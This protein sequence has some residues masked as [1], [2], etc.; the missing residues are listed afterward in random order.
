[1]FFTIF[2]H[3]LNFWFRQISTYVY[4]FSFLFVSMLLMAGTAGLFDGPTAAVGTIEFVNSPSSIFLGIDF[5]NRFIL[6]LLPIIVGLSVYRDYSSRIHSIMYTF[7]FTKQDY[8]IAK[9]LSSFLVTVLI[10]SMIGV[11]LAIGATLP[12]IDEKQIGPFNLIAYLQTYF[13]FIIPNLLFFGS[14]IFSI[15]SISRNIYA[16]FITVIVL[17][18]IQQISQ[19][20]FS[21]LDDLFLSAILDPFGKVA[22]FIDTSNWTTEDK[23]VKLLPISKYLIYNRLLFLSITA[24]IVSLF[25]KNFK[26]EE[27]GKK[28]KL[29][30][31]GKSN[32]LRTKIKRNTKVILDEVKFSF[33]LLDKLK[34]MF[35]LAK[36]DYKYIL[37]SWPFIII[38]LSS[39]IFIF[40]KQADLSPR[41]G[42]KLLPVTWS[43]L[44]MPAFFFSGI[45]NILTFLYMGVLINRARKVSMNQL[46][47]TTA[48]DSWSLMISKYLAII[49]IQSS[50]LFLII[51]AGVSVQILYDF[52]DFNFSLY[53]YEL[54][55]ITLLETIIWASL[56]LILQTIFTNEYL[57]FFILLGCSM[58]VSLLPEAGFE[59]L[60]FRFNANPDYMNALNYTDIN[61][62]GNF[63]SE[64]FAYKLYWLQVAVIFI[65]LT[66]FFWIRGLTLPIIERLKSAFKIVYNKRFYLLLI[67]L[68]STA[69]TAFKIEE[70]KATDSPLADY[71]SKKIKATELK[72][73]KYI[74][75]KQ[76][77]I[78]S[79]FVELDIYPSK[80]SFKAK[81]YY[82]LVNKTKK[83]IDTLIVSRG[84][85][86][87]TNYEFS[88]KHELISSDEYFK[89][90]IHKL[91]EP[92]KPGDS[93]KLSFSIT[94]IEAKAFD[95][96]L[97]IL[98]NGTYIK[99]DIFP[100]LFHLRANEIRTKP[101]KNE[102]Y[103]YNFQSKD[104][105]LI[106]FETIVSTNNDQTAISTGELKRKWAK[107]K[108]NYFHYKTAAKI[109]F[110]VSYHSARFEKK[111][112]KWNN[113]ELE[114]LH[115]KSHSVN[116]KSILK[117]L[118]ASLSYHS[119]YFGAYEHPSLKVIEFP[120]TKGSYA[121][122]FGNIAPFSELRF[123]ADSR[124]LSDNDIDL[125]FY[126]A[127]HEVAH[128]WWGNQVLPA[129]KLGAH[130]LSESL[131][132]LSSLNI[133]EEE[134][135]KNALRKFL[136]L[137][138]KQYQRFRKKNL[139][140]E[141][142]LIYADDAQY[143]TYRKAGVVLHA[144]STAIGKIKFNN[145]LNDFFQAAKK[146]KSPYP[147]SLDLLRVLKKETADS[148]QY[149]I[150]DGIETITLYDNKIVNVKSKRLESGQYQSVIDFN[151]TK[152]RVGENG[153][154][155]F[156]DEPLID[157]SEISEDNLRSLYLRDY[158]ELAVFSEKNELM[159]KRIKVKNIKNQLTVVTDIK[160]DQIQIDPYTKLIDVNSLDNR[161]DL[162]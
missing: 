2:K 111:V 146:M 116:N 144:L 126:V 159:L 56:A 149:M 63:L 95:R 46:V 108:R 37:K 132:E 130:F 154:K 84:Y 102:L 20:V 22:A 77:K 57:G 45:I 83:V 148:L 145:I 127:T 152:F 1:M 125:P 157:I 135:G 34:T 10:V 76:P 18:C 54:Y 21:G 124:D 134:Y 160:P 69:F 133:L 53:F 6:F 42:F 61:G 158:V 141:K 7:S 128:Q 3:E 91:A 112:D 113:V 101:N 103:H 74:N 86:E 49:M 79:V 33:T 121:T 99:T 62:Y 44:K 147:V 150:K 66:S 68:V 136:K 19:S 82:H 138:L 25:Y 16:G 29:N 85:H 80:N 107:N 97:D 41:Y 64:F 109:K 98:N 129:N 11:G 162:K 143:V 100:R 88:K 12:G 89:F 28:F 110:A 104:S 52:Y 117:A 142:P 71:S 50:L 140:T 55:V 35:F 118:K 23:N 13:I 17:F 32:K 81:G 70:V 39:L 58:A 31:K 60:L 94:S 5:F 15:V 51:V 72:F 90:D 139:A 65:L 38:V 30:K 156:A 92:I 47:D 96:N 155:V 105:D 8:L 161:Y 122:M 87:K 40:L 73:K 151:I 67:L 131:T 153:N 43:M 26:L 24:G 14:I 120:Q 114:L 137:N 27:H 4:L 9:F 36:E 106:D 78:V 123:L 115:H 48:T 59:N 119:K 75:F 93:L